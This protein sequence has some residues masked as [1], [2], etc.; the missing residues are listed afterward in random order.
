MFLTFL[1]AAGAPAARD[2]GV[3]HPTEEDGA[4]FSLYAHGKR[5]RETDKCTYTPSSIELEWTSKPAVNKMCEISR[6]PNQIKAANLWLQYAAAAAD[7]NPHDDEKAILSRFDCTDG[8]GESWVEWI[9]PLTGIARHPYAA[10][11]CNTALQPG[12]QCPGCTKTQSGY[13][14]NIFDLSYIIPTNGCDHDLHASN[15]SEEF[16]QLRSETNG[17]SGTRRIFFDLGTATFDRALGDRVWS[18]GSGTGL[19]PSL[20]IFDNTYG[21]LCL[22]LT[23]FYGWEAKN[24]PPN[25]YWNGVPAKDRARLHFYDVP[26]AEDGTQA[27]FSENLKATAAPEDWVGVKVD[28]DYVPVEHPIVKDMKNK[29]ELT[30]LVDELYFEYHFNPD[31]MSFGW[32]SAVGQPLNVPD[33]VDDALELMVGLRRKGIRAHWWI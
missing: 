21:Q 27:S 12:A 9:E 3:M 29:P 13:G 2:D 10:V 4:R 1:G 26:I 17:E 8:N 16:Q 33:T 28:I 18:Q 5:N 23:D 6:R 14:I 19:G 20:P 32:A 30:R 15:S 11:G 31:N 7:R 24:I 25:V 22:P